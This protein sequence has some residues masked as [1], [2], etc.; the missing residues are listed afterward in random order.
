MREMIESYL[1]VYF[2]SEENVFGAREKYTDNYNSIEVAD[3][4]RIVWN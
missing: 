4:K 3:I 1:R 2:L